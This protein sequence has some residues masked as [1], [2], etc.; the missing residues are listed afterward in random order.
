ML[1]YST[2]VVLG[3]HRRPYLPL[4]RRRATKGN[5]KR[6]KGNEGQR[7]ATFGPCEVESRR[8]HVCPIFLWKSD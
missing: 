8:E 1:E 7:R 4:A 6:K 2:Y 3:T 5:E